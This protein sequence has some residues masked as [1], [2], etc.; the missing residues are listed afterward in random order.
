MKYWVSEQKSDT[1]SLF[2]TLKY[3][4]D[5]N[6][7]V[8]FPNIQKVM[9]IL[10]TTSAT[11]VSGKE[12]SPPFV[13][14]KLNTGAVTDSYRKEWNVRQC[15]ASQVEVFG[16]RWGVQNRWCMKLTNL[17]AKLASQVQIITFIPLHKWPRDL[18]LCVVGLLRS[19]NMNKVRG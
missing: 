10:L 13:L 6:V 17:A 7:E 9:T 4:W 18:V 16:D 11:I 5:N 14:S 1:N 12:P 2:K 8:K 15:S 19:L 3:I